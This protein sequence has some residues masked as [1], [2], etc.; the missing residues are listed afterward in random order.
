MRRINTDQKKYIEVGLLLN[1]GKEPKLKENILQ[2]I[3]K[4]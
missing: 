2:T 1:F 3:E 4:K